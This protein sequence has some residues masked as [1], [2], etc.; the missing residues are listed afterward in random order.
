MARVKAHVG[1]NGIATGTALKT[2]LQLV[3]AANHRV[4]I[5]EI[6][7]SFHGVT[8]TDAPILVQAMRQ[9]TA[10]TMSA[11]TPVKRNST[12]DETLQTTAQHTAT[13]EPTAGDV[14]KQWAIHPQGGLVYQPAPGEEIVVPGGGKLG[15]TVTAGVSINA[16]V[17]VDYEE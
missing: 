7:I 12:D 15:I 14:L 6:G 3:A 4:V 8:P 9:T 5:T 11:A 2:L 17:Y 1:Q 16:D 13:V 10:G